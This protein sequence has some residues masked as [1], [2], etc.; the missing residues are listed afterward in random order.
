[1]SI[2]YSE[3]V[4]VALGIQYWVHGQYYIVI[5][6]LSCSTI[7]FQKLEGKSKHTFYFQVLFFFRK[8]YRFWGNVKKYGIARQPM[9]DNII[10]RMRLAS[11]ITKATDTHSE[12][13]IIFC[14]S[15]TTMFNAN[16]C[17][18]Y[19]YTC[20]ACVNQISSWITCNVCFFLCL[21]FNAVTNIA[22]S[23]LLICWRFVLRLWIVLLE[24]SSITRDLSFRKVT[25]WKYWCAVRNVQYPS[26]KL[27]VV[28]PRCTPGSL[29]LWFG[30]NSRQEKYSCVLPG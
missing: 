8:S 20:I 14:F 25:C 10:R 27:T 2:T 4:F 13:V 11:R 15:T 29:S 7:F 3:C 6:G 19:V 18:F 9:D 22:Y 12:C 1:M 5:R 23:L 26:W 17:Q 30:Y 28:D 16:A 21:P 24:I